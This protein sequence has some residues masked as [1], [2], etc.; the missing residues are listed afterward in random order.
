MVL[1]DGYCELHCEKCDEKYQNTKYKWCR[2]CQTSGNEQI[3]DFIQE[4]QLN[5]NWNDDIGFEWIPYNQF[6]SI[7]EVR[8]V[9]LTTIYSAIWKDGPLNWHG[10][11]GW[12]RELHKD[13]NITLKC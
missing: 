5:I 4:K 3:D 8:K 11:H 13:I 12:T 9:E 7:K 1:Q 10:Y 6:N 2:F